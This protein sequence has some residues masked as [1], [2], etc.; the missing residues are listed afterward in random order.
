MKKISLIKSKRHV[1]YTKESFVLIKMMKIIK[2]EKRLKI[3]AIKDKFRGAAHSKCTLNYKIPKDIPII[4]HNASYD[5]HF[6]INQ[7]AEEFKGEVN[8][9]GEN[10]EQYITFSAPIKKK[11]CDNDKTITYKL[12]FIDSFRFMATSSSELVDNMS[13][14]FNSTECK[15]YTENNRCEECKKLIEGLI[16]KFP[17]IY[18]FCNSDLNKFILLL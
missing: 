2:T 14:N 16:K 5:T 15:S 13:G 11:K 6:I 1:I 3:T 10:M 17:S 8:C 9:I 7:S 18:Q 12:R 4:N